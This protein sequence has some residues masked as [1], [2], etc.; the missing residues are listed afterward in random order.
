MPNEGAIIVIDS[1][2]QVQPAHA[3]AIVVTGSHGGRSSARYAAKVRA[4]L[5][6]FNDAGIGRDEAGVAALA[7][8]D[9]YGIAAVAVSHESARIGDAADTL[10][11]GVISR[12]NDVASKLG[13]RP[14]MPL[15]ML[16][17]K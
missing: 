1:I 12:I 6:V 11:R 2:T 15:A 4:K 7:M 13:A 16:F 17:A 14:D 5:Y 8:L 10:D 9:R 3:G